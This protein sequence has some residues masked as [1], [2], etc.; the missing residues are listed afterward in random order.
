MAGSVSAV[1]VSDFK[2]GSAIGKKY[3][4]TLTCD[5][6]GNLSGN[7]ILLNSRTP[8]SGFLML[9]RTVSGTPSPA[10]LYDLSLLDDKG[11]DI[12]SGYGANRSGTI[13][14]RIAF[15]EATLTVGALTPVIA[16]GVTSGAI[17]TLE[18]FIVGM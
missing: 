18:L 14:E 2:I 11:I 17:V 12:L 3:T 6:S 15:S 9:V 1:T 4:C 10:N 16:N 13:G 8:D 7:Q 5:A